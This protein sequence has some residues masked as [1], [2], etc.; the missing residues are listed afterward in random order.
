[1]KRVINISFSPQNNLN[2]GWKN[3]EKGQIKAK[4]KTLGNLRGAVAFIEV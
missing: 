4:Y 2:P 1:V 3:I